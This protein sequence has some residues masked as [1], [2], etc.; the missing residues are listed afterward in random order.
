M[1]EL[2]QT[3]R[4]DAERAQGIARDIFG[5]EAVAS[6]LESERDQNFRLE[7]SDGARYVLKI[8][9]DGESRDWLEAQ[10]A[11]MA[12]ASGRGALC[13][14]IVPGLDG[15]E[16]ATTAG[17]AGSVHMVRLLT[18]VGGEPLGRLRYH[19][20]GLLEDLGRRLGEL[21][22]IL[23]DFDHAALH[24]EFH[25]D[26]R[27][28]SA[29]VTEHLPDIADEALRRLVGDL[30]A[31]A[32]AAVEQSAPGLPTGTIHNDANDY[33]V[34][35]VR[36]ESGAQRI[37]GFIDFG[38]LMH[39]W[40]V[41]DLAIAIAYAMLD[42]ADPLAVAR[43]LA[44]AY[45]AVHPLTEE[46]AGILF[47]LAVLRLCLSASIAASQT[48]LRPD[49]P[50]LAISQ[51]P[52]A[53]TL[54][55]LAVI[56]RG[57][58]SAAIRHA[59]GF[60][61]I[62]GSSQIER[63]LHACQVAPVI[64]V[65]PSR[66]VVLDLSV[67]SPLVDSD[68]SGNAEPALTAR[69][70]RI[71]AGRGAAGGIGRYLEPRLL[72]V[73]PLF[74]GGSPDAERRTI[75]LG[76][77]LFVPAGTVVHAPIDGTV[78]VAAENV[79][80][81]DYGPVI[82][83]EHRTTEGDRFFTLYGHLT[84]ESLDRLTPGRR[85]AA[86]E[87]LAAVGVA[88]VNG[89][90]PP[91]LH[92]Q[93]IVDLLGLGADFPG[94]C[95]ASEWPIWRSLSPSPNAV[96]R[97]PGAEFSCDGL[98]TDR[99]V[100]A[101]RA[102]IGPSV[103]LGYREPLR[104]ARGWMQHLYDWSG[105]RYLDAYNNVPHV[106]HSHPRVA[107]A[108]AAQMRVLNT[109]TRYLQDA[110]GAY[111]A[112]LTA[113]LPDPLRVC[114]FVNSGTEANELALRLA[115]AHTRRQ[116][117]LVLDAAYHG[118]SQTMIEV[119]PYKFNGPGGQGA[120]PWV[121]VA[122]LPDV[123]RG[124]YRREDA[125]AKHAH[126]VG[127]LIAHLG[128]GRLAAFLA[129]TCPSVAGQILLPDGYLAAVYQHVRAAGGICIADEVQTACGRMGSHF[130]AFQAHGV[131]PDIV[132]LGK[133]IGNGYP[134]GAVV[135][136]REVAESFDNG[137]EFFST[138]GGSTVSCIVGLAVLDVVEEESLQ[139]HARQVGE[140]LGAGLRELKARH[141]LIGD[142]RGSGLFWGVELV[143]N[144]VDLDPAAAQAGY[145]MNRLRDEGILIGTDGPQHNV[146][147]IRPPMP[148]TSADATRLVEMLDRT[149]GELESS[150]VA[151]RTSHV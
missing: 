37:S 118:H 150:H 82:I 111:A 36:D 19:S 3:P 139:G 62:P 148:F 100:A 4:F 57:F 124:S 136:T 120:R 97:L 135:T 74:D 34:L 77:D 141:E 60:E 131:I 35:V 121:H 67:G 45:H 143:T 16:I 5:V 104:I 42:A 79:A 105:R 27:R 130:Y 44:G 133:P 58:A 106:G 13:P 80:P 69:I 70:Q 47:D 129:E 53:R 43:R 7:T 32:G 86:G 64:D 115:R 65:D 83:L 15:A 125:A 138:F 116:D 72:Y 25:W 151:R 33:N 85:V 48:R 149:L 40:R 38:D 46:E 128:P 30:A 28:A 145:V 99:S 103:R 26:L 89:G 56:P 31:R 12:H 20:P 114:Y 68:P 21:D 23:A 95:R 24:R 107:E 127:V 94:V 50:Y 140:T 49:D 10:N 54:P 84:R 29:T 126:D 96:L 91:H 66:M 61:P 101:R 93:V 78:V 88:D 52:I 71:Q 134:V 132:V 90:W 8:A 92:F 39:G 146:L 123:Y 59:C 51:P 14:S 110:L 142:V 112:R 137:M 17:G 109:N 87:A 6:P 41:A 9:N 108:A 147:K 11:A 122:A 1:P 2:G 18:W 22:A 81:L 76:I 63:W 98:L 119:S 113:T 73:S 117:V 102:R 75:H 144:G 55:T